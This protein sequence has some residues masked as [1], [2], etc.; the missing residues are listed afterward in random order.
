MCPDKGKRREV[1]SQK[2]NET[3]KLRELRESILNLAEEYAAEAHTCAQ[4]VPGSTHVPI[5]GKVYGASE[6]RNLVDSSLDFWLTTGRY[7]EAFEKKLRAFLGVKHAL[8][9]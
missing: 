7:N 9:S 6:M 5:S 2:L 1:L 8:H 4:F 3:E